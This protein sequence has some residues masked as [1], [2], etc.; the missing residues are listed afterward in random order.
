MSTT[1]LH[2]RVRIKFT[3]MSGT[4]TTGITLL[5]LALAK[6]TSSSVVIRKLLAGLVRKVSL[7]GAAAGVVVVLSS[8][9]AKA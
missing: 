7:P 6:L 3:P 4:G 9:S 2:T 1:S 8:R 5:A